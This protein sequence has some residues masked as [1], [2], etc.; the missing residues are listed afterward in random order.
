MR[1]LTL[2]HRWIGGLIG[3]LLATLGLSG[4]VLVHRDKWILLPH[5][6]DALVTDTAVVAA[7]VERLMADPATRPRSIGFASETLGLHQ[8]TLGEKM[9]AYTDQAGNVVSRWHSQW[10]RPELWLFDFHHHLL[11]GDAGEAVA[12]I[13]GLCGLFIVISGTTLWW[14]TRKTF[15]LR[16]WPKRM[17]RPAIIRQHRDI[18][19]VCAPLLLLS[20]YTGVVLIFPTTI[21]LVFGPS[22]P[23]IIREGLK[24]PPPMGLQV[25]QRLDWAEMIHTAR[26][27]FPDAEFRRLSLPRGDNGRIIIRMKQPAEWTPNG[28]TM[29]YFAADTGRLGGMRDALAQPAQVQWVDMIYPMHAAKIGGIA[30]QIT[31]TIAG[32]ALTLLGSL[33]VWTFWFKRPDGR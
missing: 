28:R 19:V 22:A 3:L 7:T 13:A 12:G 27:R 21:A 14:R 10:E 26:D 6:H 30:Y 2:L 4:A 31:M 15:S 9:G 32:L 33:A 1:L 23:A 29:V 25:A 11:V 16:L 8:L 17:S 5:A 20:L 18:G 24:A